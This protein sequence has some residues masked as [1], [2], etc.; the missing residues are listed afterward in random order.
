MSKYI[1]YLEQLPNGFLHI[2]QAYANDNKNPQIEPAHLLRAL[3]HKSINLYHVIE[4]TL[5][6]DY[7]Y[8]VD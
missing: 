7:Y 5:N 4:D 6:A 8:L 3:L 1:D 2:A